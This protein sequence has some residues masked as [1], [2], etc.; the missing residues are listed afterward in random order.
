MDKMYTQPNNYLEKGH[1]GNTIKGSA[2]LFT[3]KYSTVHTKSS[4]VE[5]TFAAHY[6]ALRHFLHIYTPL[7][8]SS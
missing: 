5:I 1:V 7:I 4:S 6:K 2:I 8:R 3:Q